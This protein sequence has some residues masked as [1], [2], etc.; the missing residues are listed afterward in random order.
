MPDSTMLQSQYAAQIQSDLDS[1]VAEREHIAGQISALQEQ[2]SILESNHALLASMQ[3]AIG[4]PA[5][6]AAGKAPKKA[7]ASAPRIPQARSG[8]KSAGRAA[9]KQARPAPKAKA[10]GAAPTLR[11]LVA[12]HLATSGEPRSA[13][14]ITAGLTDAHPGRNIAGTVV[15]N[16]LENLVAK[17]QA[18]R[19]RQNR[20]VF[21]TAPEGGDTSASAQPADSDVKKGEDAVTPVT[22][23]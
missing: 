11:E 23:D 10:S 6:P 3:Q 8:S 20:S 18:Q 5:V 15:R 13:A 19:T 12:A 1:N 7:E 14:E 17:G 21:Y 2:L 22:T 9:K 4:T 16:T